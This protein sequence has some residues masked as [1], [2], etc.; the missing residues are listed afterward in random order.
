MLEKE[1]CRESKNPLTL[2]DWLRYKHDFRQQH[3]DYFDPDG[4]AIFVGGQG[5]GKTL[6]AVN[7]AYT[8]C[9]RLQSLY[10]RECEVNLRLQDVLR[11]HGIP[12]RS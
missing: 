2:R 4:L 10:A 6:S 11:E 7:Y 12:F 1:L 8:E 9:I 5:T 3:P